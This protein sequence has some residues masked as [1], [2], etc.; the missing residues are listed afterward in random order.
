MDYKQHY[1]HLIQKAK[2]RVLSGYFEVHHIVPRCLNGS[3]HSDNLVNLTPEEHYLAHLLL[4][5]INPSNAKLA[6]A[7]MMMC[8]NRKGNKV[9][10]WL[11]RRH[12][13][14]MSVQQSG[15][16]NSQFGTV[17]I[18]KSEFSKKIPKEK[19]NEYI[20]AGW[21]LGRKQKITK[22][23]KNKDLGINSKKY[24]WITDN[25]NQVLKEFDE[26]KSVNKILQQRGF[27]N[28]EGN[29]I[30]SNWLKSKGRTV[31]KRR[32]SAGVA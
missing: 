20:D 21:Q 22:I 29:K 8:A 5:K 10:G 13:Q 12:S 19:I 11:R 31:L 18:Y 24:K 9:Y 4:V 2:H 1:N 25:E 6:S 7:A 16:R 23:K 26:G 15:E 32:N 27:K 28:R 30:L 14:A 3:D 17:W